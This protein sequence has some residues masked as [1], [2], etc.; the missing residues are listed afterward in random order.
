MQPC[1]V[2]PRLLTQ[3]HDP[4]TSCLV[5]EHPGL[6]A[7]TMSESVSESF[8]EL[9]TSGDST[10]INPSSSAKPFTKARTRTMSSTMSFS[11]MFAQSPSADHSRNRSSESSFYQNNR[12]RSDTSESAYSS[13]GSP[14]SDS[15]GFGQVVGSPFSVGS[16]EQYMLG[17]PPTPVHSFT[18]PSKATSPALTSVETD[19]SGAQTAFRDGKGKGKDRAVSVDPEESPIVLVVDDNNGNSAPRPIVQGSAIIDTSTVTEMRSDHLSDMRH[20][21]PSPLVHSNTYSGPDMSANADSGG[22]VLTYDYS[23]RSTPTARSATSSIHGKISSM[24]IKLKRKGSSLIDV[25]SFK[26]QS[27][28]RSEVNTP[29]EG[30][31]TT[32]SAFVEEGN[33]AS[34]I[35]SQGQHSNSKKNLRTKIANKFDFSASRS[36]ALQFTEK[37]TRTANLPSPSGTDSSP[38]GP[39]PITLSNVLNA[40]QPSRTSPAAAVDLNPTALL[41]VMPKTTIDQTPIC[42]G[43]VVS[44]SPIAIPL[45]PISPP[46]LDTNHHSRIDALGGSIPDFE[47]LDSPPNTTPALMTVRAAPISQR[48]SSFDTKLPPELKLQVFATILDLHKAEHDRAIRNVRATA[49]KEERAY[50]AKYLNNRWIGEM[51]GRRELFC[52]SRASHLSRLAL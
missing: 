29:D 52:I 27:A 46:L 24:R 17:T 3:E 40:G 51:A 33:T 48:V 45:S 47:R 43:R 7:R 4:P 44:E 19:P 11:A 22:R 23:G 20:V 32:S 1:G 34:R 35:P 10:S 39:G 14:V 13:I 9:S 16:D 28:S 30:S 26:N 41:P 6:S 49:S 8:S 42:L 38:L 50:A 36:G 15:S 18:A 5:H 31:S 12:S 37:Q 21:R 25:M 2:Q